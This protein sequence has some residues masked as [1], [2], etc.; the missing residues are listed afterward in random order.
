MPPRISGTRV[1]HVYVDGKGNKQ[2][3][4]PSPRGAGFGE[5]VQGM[6]R[7]Q[8]ISTGAA[9]TKLTGGGHSGHGGH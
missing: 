9:R 7:R 4:N 3:I 1:T 2:A 8:K 6:A 5:V